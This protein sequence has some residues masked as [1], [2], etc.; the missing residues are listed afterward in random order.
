MK[1]PTTTCIIDRRIL[2]NRCFYIKSLFL[3]SPKKAP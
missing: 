2:V 3:Q 1:I